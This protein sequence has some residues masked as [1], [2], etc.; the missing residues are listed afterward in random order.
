[1]LRRLLVMNGVIAACEF[2]DDGSVTNAAGQI[3][4]E[5]MR[6]LARFALW[7]RR[8]ISGN[9]DAFSL[10]SQM[11]GWAPSRGWIVRGNEMTVC[12]IANYVALLDSKSASIDA[13][14]KGL[15]D[16]AIL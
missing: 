11:N 4:D 14:M 9:T 16:V 2:Q 8:M 13:V 6:N 5:T 3:P 7:Y 12:C 10:F 1:M 15:E